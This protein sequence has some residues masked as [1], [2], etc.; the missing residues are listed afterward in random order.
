MDR[1][2]DGWMKMNECMNEW[3]NEQTNKQTNRWMDG[4]MGGRKNEQTKE[5]MNKQTNERPNDRKNKRMNEISDFMHQIYL[6]LCGH[7]YKCIVKDQRLVYIE[8]WSHLTLQTHFHTSSYNT[9]RNDFMQWQYN[10]W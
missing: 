2:M 10:Y 6:K 9:H 1:W 4:W 7:Y 3:T 5:W 8:V